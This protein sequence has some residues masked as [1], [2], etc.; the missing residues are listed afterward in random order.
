MKALIEQCWS[1]HPDK[2]PEF[3]QIVKVLEEFE[4]S[5]ARDGTL[6]LLQNPACNDHKKGLRHW[7]H[8]LGPTHQTT[9]SMPKPKFY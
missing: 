7:I 1:L 9:T 4:F 2:R 5:L 3:W 6:N 8:K